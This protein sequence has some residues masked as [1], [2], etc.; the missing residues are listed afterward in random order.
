MDEKLKEAIAAVRMGDKELAQ[1]Q[2]T[3]LL[4]EDPQQVQGWYLL[5]LLVDSPQKQAAYLSKTLTLN[6]NHEKAKEQLAALQEAGTLA[7]TTNVTE[8]ASQPMDVLAQSETSE[9]PDWLRE[10]SDEE[11]VTAVPATPREE[12]AVVNQNLPDW[13][14]EPAAV[15]DTLP[16]TKAVEES[17]TM[18]GKT[19][20][21]VTKPGKAAAGPQKT[22][23]KSRQKQPKA[24]RSTKQTTRNLNMLLGLLV[25]LAV[26]VMILLAYLLFS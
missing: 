13:L 4:D 17:P 6:P 20:A 10:A 14:K 25:T 16:A 12:T 15:A 8:E 1:R 24:V 26:I 9:L 5:S 18:V 7:P 2:L 19:A 23:D 22:L 21:S 3:E 11:T